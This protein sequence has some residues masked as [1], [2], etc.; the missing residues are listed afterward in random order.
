MRIITLV[1]NSCIDGLDCAHGLAL[2]IETENHKILFDAGP[3][4]KLLLSNAKKLGVELKEVDIAILSHGH[5]D[6]AGGLRAFL[7]INSIARVFIHPLAATRGHYATENVGWR[8][9]GI[10][11][12]LIS[13]YKERIRLTNDI[14]AIDKE[15]L[16]FSD[17]RS[18]EFLSASNSSLFEEADGEYIPDPFKHEHS[19]LIHEGKNFCLVAGCAHR[20]IINI[21]RRVEDIC[22]EAPSYVIAGFHLTNPGLGQD[23]PADFVRQ[24]GKELKKYSSVY[25][26]G[27]CT[28]ANAFA[29]L[30]EELADRI[31]K[32]TSG[33]NVTL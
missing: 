29:I 10:D 7:E 4:G 20:G 25:Y 14:H 18:S 17:I 26:T 28:G 19:L 16:L 31:H 6:H 8:D 32:L 1:E 21:I 22:D 23:L 27:H 12:N 15:L 5:Y 13:D 33:L 30:K 2:Y 3:D 11:R 24:V 9:I